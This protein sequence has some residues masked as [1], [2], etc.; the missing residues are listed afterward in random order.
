[1]GVSNNLG[2]LD[3]DSRV[4]TRFIYLGIG[5]VIN[6]EHDNEASGSIKAGS[7]STS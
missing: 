3:V 2:D 6:C 4:W 5:M 1:M 7:F